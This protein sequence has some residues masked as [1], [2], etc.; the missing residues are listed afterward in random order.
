MSN[1]VVKTAVS[2][3]ADGSELYIEFEEATGT[4]HVTTN[5]GGFDTPNPSRNSLAAVLVAVHALV[6]GDQPAV[7][8]AYNP[9]SSTSF[10]IT[11]TKAVNGVLKYDLLLI[12][13]FDDEL[14]Y[15]DGD[16]TYDNTN[17]STPVIQELVLGVWTARTA[18]QVI[19]NANVDQKNGYSFPIPEAFFYQKELL[20]DNL[21][22][23][24]PFINQGCDCEDKDY[25][26]ANTK[27]N[28]I[29]GLICTAT[30]AYRAQAY[31]EA[32]KNI[33]KIFDYQLATI[34]V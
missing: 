20:L 33:E 4:Y 10:T 11:L 3:K 34:A 31:N 9:I 8:Q 27:Y 21:L 18:Q 13:I 29:S 14:T 6:A 12:P 2:L 19:G 32:Q 25:E 5:P 15:D 16:I 30:D 24:E 22:K 17:P 26:L 7:I 23:L 1:L 28:W